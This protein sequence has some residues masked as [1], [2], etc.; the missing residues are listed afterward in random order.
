MREVNPADSWMVLKRHGFY[1]V[2][3]EGQ[4]E[5]SLWQRK[6][7]CTGVGSSTQIQF[8]VSLVHISR[9]N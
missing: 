3:I 5:W 4:N 9:Q 2:V 7:Y 1:L 8:L 6:S